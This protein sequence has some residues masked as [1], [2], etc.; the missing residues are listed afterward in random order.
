MTPVP[1]IASFWGCTH[2][3][4]CTLRRKFPS[5]KPDLRACRGYQGTLKF[6]ILP[7][8][9]FCSGH[10]YFVQGM[11]FK[12]KL[13]PYVV[14]ATFQFSGTPGKRFRFREAL[15]WSVRPSHYPIPYILYP[16]PLATSAPLV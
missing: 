16:N 15:L 6:G 12:L 3:V 9:T 11:P 14:H 8:S 4:P 2:P 5:T 7:V 10:T 1:N 13:E